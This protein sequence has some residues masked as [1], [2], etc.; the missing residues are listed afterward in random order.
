MPEQPNSH[1]PSPKTTAG[2][3]DANDDDMDNNLSSFDERMKSALENLEVPYEPSTWAALEQRISQAPAAD[4]VDKA[5]FSA[6]S[7][8]EAPYQSSHWNILA[9]RMVEQTRLRRRLWASKLAEAAVFLL[10]LANLDGVLGDGPTTT[11]KP[12]APAASDKPIAQKS[13]RHH[14]AAGTGAASSETTTQPSS[15]NPQA[16]GT[17]GLAERF[18]ASGMMLTN[19]DPTLNTTDNQWIEGATGAPASI[20]SLTNPRQ[21]DGTTST[22]AHA[23]QPAFAW[24]APLSATPQG[25]LFGD[26][27]IL[28]PSDFPL[29]NPVVVAPSKAPKQQ[30]FYAASFASLEKNHT[31]T[32]GALPQTT[33]GY[34]GGFAA[35]YRKGKW[36]VEAGV[37]YSQRRFRPRKEVEIV[38]GNIN[39]GYY[40]AYVRE[41][42][43]DMVSVPVK[44]TRR[45]VK[46][47]RL[48]AHAVAG[49]TANIAVEKSYQNKTVFYPGFQPQPGP[50]PVQQP[51]GI[52]QTGDGLLEGS[53]LNGNAYLSA[54]AGLR[55]E[56]PVGKRYTVFVEGAY[57][58][59]LTRQ[60]IGPKPAQIN[61]LALQ[62]GVMA[63]L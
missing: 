61:T 35:G 55:L 50:D 42:N 44:A 30:R 8:L 29:A 15:E 18:S 7:H 21:L 4:A 40:G 60:G 27:K 54:T 24:L 9:E 16:S 13:L 56:H 34:G 12:A 49:L 10:L 22:A 11:P 36:G 52:A 32:A 47:G 53:S 1:P 45:I 6:L 51:A 20:R 62:A 46:A 17:A 63:G 2:K 28:S 57:N 31:Q 25:P 43:A 38:S 37:A 23:P 59:A 14:Q 5:V 48:T 41:V 58:P 26:K 3:N 39:K 19:G 33:P